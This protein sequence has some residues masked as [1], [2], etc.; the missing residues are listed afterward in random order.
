MDE[1]I[2]LQIMGLQPSQTQTQNYAIVLGE[3]GGDMRLPIIIGAFEAQAIAVFIEQMIPNAP[4]THDVFAL[5]GAHLDFKVT[6]AVITGLV[7]GVFQSSIFITQGDKN[8]AIPVRTSDAVAIAIRFYAPIYVKKFV[9]DSAGMI[10][11][12]QEPEAE[13][14]LQR[15]GQKFKAVLLFLSN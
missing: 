2:E 6:K 12:E 8:I 5:L 14:W 4:L 3:K 9:L 7:D 11:E 13:N 15:I 1:E 10:L